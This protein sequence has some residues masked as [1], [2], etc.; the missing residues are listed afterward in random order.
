MMFAC[1]AWEYEVRGPRPGA[2]LIQTAS[3]T[4]S[5]GKRVWAIWVPMPPVPTLRWGVWPASRSD[6]TPM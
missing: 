1:A 4:L 5:T 6:T 2:A 3:R